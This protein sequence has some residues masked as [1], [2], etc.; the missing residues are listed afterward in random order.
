M[1]HLFFRFHRSCMIHLVVP[2]NCASTG[3]NPINVYSVLLTQEVT[4]SVIWSMLTTYT[5]SEV[6]PYR[7]VDVQAGDT[8]YWHLKHASSHHKSFPMHCHNIFPLF[9]HS[10]WL[11]S[12]SALDHL[13]NLNKLLLNLQLYTRTNSNCS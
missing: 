8:Q 10:Q 9:L 12:P 4:S 2:S 1:H 5:K 11:H 3:P 6:H 7:W 13:C